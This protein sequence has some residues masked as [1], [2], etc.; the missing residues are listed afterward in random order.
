[1]GEIG[2][3]SDFKVTPRQLRTDLN[4]LQKS[5]REQSSYTGKLRTDIKEVQEKRGYHPKALATIRQLDDMPAKERADVLRTLLPML[6]AVKPQW[7]EETADML[8]KAADA[9]KSEEDEAKKLADDLAK[10]GPKSP[11]LV[12]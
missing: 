11:A 1:M 4:K 12:E 3:N 10:N 9:A 6:E 2:H 8:D 5:K 7:D